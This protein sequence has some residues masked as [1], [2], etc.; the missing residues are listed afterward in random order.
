MSGLPAIGVM[1]IA[2]PP[3]ADLR[4][5]MIHASRLRQTCA[6]YS[7]C[8]ARRHFRRS[9]ER[10]V[11]EAPAKNARLAIGRIIE[12][13]SLAGRYAFLARNEIDLDPAG[14]AA[15]PGRLRRPRRAHLDEH[16]VPAGAQRLFD[17]AL[18]QPIDFAQPHP[19]RA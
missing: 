12:H 2:P 3:M 4:Q 8:V 5:T 11:D 13:A 16:L 17:R 15:L 19:A 6:R 1:Y 7:T 18:A 14:A 10:A 9:R